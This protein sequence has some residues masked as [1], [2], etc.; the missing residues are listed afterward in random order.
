MELLEEAI[1][2]CNTG[3]EMEITKF[4]KLYRKGEFIYPSVL[5]R[6]VRISKE[7]A[8][9]VLQKLVD[10][11]VLQRKREYRCTSHMNVYKI[12]EDTDNHKEFYCDECD[13]VLTYFSY[14]YIFS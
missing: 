8:E 3:K 4:L 7:M 13:S 14:L 5:S 1:K 6:N 12:T 9:S 10:K 11:G 2:E